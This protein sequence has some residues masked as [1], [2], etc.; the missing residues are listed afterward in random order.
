MHNFNVY[1]IFFKNYVQFKDVLCWLIWKVD[2]FWCSSFDVQFMI[3]Q[4]QI[5]KSVT[6]LHNVLFH[7]FFTNYQ[8]PKVDDVFELLNHWLKPHHLQIFIKL[9]I[10]YDKSESY[11]LVCAYH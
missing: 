6:Y 8:F 5:V 1:V 3:A 7:H 2:F 9:N 4:I 11:S 10:L